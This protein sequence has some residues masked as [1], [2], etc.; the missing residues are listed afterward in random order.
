MRI[1]Y[2]QGQKLRQK[3]RITMKKQ[4]KIA[5]ASIGA[6]CIAVPGI[7]LLYGLHCRRAEAGTDTADERIAA[8][9]HDE[10]YRQADSAERKQRAGELLQA[11]PKEHCIYALDFSEENQMYSFR[12]ADGSLGG[13]TLQD[14]ESGFD[15]LPM[16]QS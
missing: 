13:I 9:M 2:K 8:L 11:L 1:I 3:E 16:N 6:L 15:S 5:I 7:L 12:F 10:A 14:F 4:L